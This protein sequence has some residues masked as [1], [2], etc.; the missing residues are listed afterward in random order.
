MHN[1][2]KTDDCAL[3]SKTCGRNPSA[4]PCSKTSCLPPKCI[5]ICPS[6]SSSCK[7][8]ICAQPLIRIIRHAGQYT[9]CTKPSNISN[10]PSGP[11]PLKYVLNTDAEDDTSHDSSKEVKYSVEAKFNDYHFDY[12]SSESSFVL[13]FTPPEQKCYKP[14]VKKNIMCMLCQTDKSWLGKCKKYTKGQ[15]DRAK[16]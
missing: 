4:S 14:C 5:S 7:S 13:D 9:I 11:Y 15:M 16:E 2:M 8:P 10:A 1:C 6:T 12:T 3:C